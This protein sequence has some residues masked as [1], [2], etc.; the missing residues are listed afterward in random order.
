MTSILHPLRAVRQQR[1]LTIEQLA[2]GANVGAS[3]IW[4][5]E[6]GH[7]I[8]AESRR[9]LCAYLGST[10]Q[11]LGLVGYELP[12]TSTL[13][14]DRDLVPMSAKPGVLTER[15]LLVEELKASVSH[16][17]QLFHTLPPAY[18][19][20]A[21]RAQLTIVQQS[22]AM[23]PEDLCAS[24]FAALYNLKG[25]TLF[26]QGQ[27]AEAQRAHKKAYLMASEVADIWDMSQ[28]LTWQAIVMTRYGSYN[29]SIQC[30]EMALRLVGQR[31]DEQYL[32]LRAHLLADWAY[33]AALLDEQRMTYEK[34]D[35]S[36]KML[37][38]LGPNEEFDLAQWCQI[39]GNC[40]L[41]RGDHRA[42]IAQFEASLRHIPA[43]WQ[44]RRILSLLPLAEAYAL[45]GERDRSLAL[46][47]QAM[48]LLQALH[49]TR[50]DER[51]VAFQ[52]VLQQAFP[53]DQHVISYVGTTRGTLGTDKKA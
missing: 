49:S 40:A 42:A 31:R 52:R 3:T 23:I 20:V 25:G 37:E 26:A 50:L 14:A 17:W 15:D 22:R 21:A 46:A 43:S 11:A 7:A 30:L 34:L 9:R 1:N 44:A 19:A 5:A 2:E 18:V 45:Y 35:H 6:H 16:V 47:D 27:Y 29:E 8:N 32:R 12:L 10:S 28:S 36:A 48:A 33:N 4:R 38:G 51:F 13:S 53:T 39:A 41:I 24:L